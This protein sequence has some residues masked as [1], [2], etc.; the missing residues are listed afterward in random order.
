MFTH[1]AKLWWHEEL[2]ALFGMR[3]NMGETWMNCRERG[4]VQSLACNYL[5]LG[6]YTTR[7][8]SGLIV[9]S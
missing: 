6:T 2:E 8:P 1:K 9:A 7:T 4:K 5:T 3:D